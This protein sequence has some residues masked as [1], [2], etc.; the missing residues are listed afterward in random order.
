MFNY[1]YKKSKI[2]K[3]TISTFNFYHEFRKSINSFYNDRE[4]QY[5]ILFDF[6]KLINSK[7]DNFVINYTD[8]TIVCNSAFVSDKNMS[9]TFNKIVDS[10]TELKIK[11]ILLNY[12]IEIIVIDEINDISLKY[13]L[14]NSNSDIYVMIYLSKVYMVEVLKEL[15]RRGW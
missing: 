5:D 3:S 4:I 8:Y 9:V 10:S 12:E 15:L 1:L 2:N 13:I 14:P 7:T 6:I 11:Y